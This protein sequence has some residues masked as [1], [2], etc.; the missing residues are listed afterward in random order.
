MATIHSRA[1][2]RLMLSPA[3]LMLLGWM[4]IPLSMAV[5][6]SFLHYNLLIPGTHDFIGFAN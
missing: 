1:A 6:F 5:Y 4:I 3:V 2:A